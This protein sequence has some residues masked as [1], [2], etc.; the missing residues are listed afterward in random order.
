MT[1][2][3][4]FLRSVGFFRSAGRKGM[5]FLTS[6]ALI[7]LGGLLLGG[8]CSKI[9]LPPLVGILAAGL[10]CGQTILTFAVLAI[11]ITA[12]LGAL[13]TDISYKKLLNP[14]YT[15]QTPTAE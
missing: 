2:A 13:L 8:L 14:A 6:I 11:L 7:C 9:K 5:D 3:N 12:P 4:L 15:A 10:A 1:S